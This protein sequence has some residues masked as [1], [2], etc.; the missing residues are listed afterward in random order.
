M[1]ELKI[2]E[3][4]FVIK[5]AKRF[6]GSNTI[7]STQFFIWLFVHNFDYWD[8]RRKNDTI[9]WRHENIHFVQEKELLFIGFWILYVLNYLINLFRFKFDRREAYKNIAFELEAK[10]MNGQTS[11]LSKRKRFAW[12]KW[13]F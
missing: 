11:Y 2:I 7:D 12:T 8:L 10:I 5:W 3:S 1:K 4:K 13:L 6:S 9:K